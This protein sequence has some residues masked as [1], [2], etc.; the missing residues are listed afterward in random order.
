MQLFRKGVGGTDHLNFPGLPSA[1]VWTVKFQNTVCRNYWSPQEK[2]GKKQQC[3]NVEQE[4]HFSPLER[5][6]LHSK[7]VESSTANRGEKKNHSKTAKKEGI[8]LKMS[9]LE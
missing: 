1:R 9:F 7:Q 2:P 5:P 3:W 6:R 4:P 8:L